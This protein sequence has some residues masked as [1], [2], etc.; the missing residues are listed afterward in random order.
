M[1]NITI[2]DL[3]IN[4]ELDSKA[5]ENIQGGRWVRRFAGY[6]TYY[7]TRRYTRTYYRVIRRR[8][9]RTYYRRYRVRRAIYRW[10]W[11]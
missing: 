2:Q 9:T 1:A 7:R 8:Y 10:R 5:M 11:V 6:R 4:E 3:D